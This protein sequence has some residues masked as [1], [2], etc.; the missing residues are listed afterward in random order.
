MKIGTA[1][2]GYTKKKYFKQ[3]DGEVIYRILPPLGELADQGRW[4]M[5]YRIHYGYKNT[6]GQMRVFQTSLVKNKKKMIEVPDAA[7]ERIE[8]LKAQLDLAKKNGNKDLAEK[9]SELVGPMGRF[10]LD[11]NHYMNVIDLN[12]NI[13]ILKLR[14]KAKLALDE[15][16]KRLRD[17]GVDPLSVNDG[18]FFIFR[19]SGKGLETTFSVDVFKEKLHVE[20][21]GQVER[22]VVHKLDDE[23][24]SR[25]SSEAGELNKLFKKLS[26]EEIQSIVDTTDINTGKSTAIDALFSTDEGSSDD[27]SESDDSSESTSS[28]SSTESSVAA[29]SASDAGLSSIVEN[30]VESTPAEV[31]T[32]ASAPSQE[33]KTSTPISSYSQKTAEQEQDEF[34]KNLGLV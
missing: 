26:A 22:E 32:Q 6:K 17:K 29:S 12:G 8:K 18:R 9:L 30:K 3:K 2:Y 25:L 19:R 10:N 13:G 28:E 34:L 20:G 1:K 4:S 7:V 11:S 5:F 31:S 33:E 21:V 15:V 14:H 27:D 23:L 24:I 16:I